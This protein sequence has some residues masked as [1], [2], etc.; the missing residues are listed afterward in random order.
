[1]LRLRYA[2]SHR[3][4]G[5]AEQRPALPS[6]VS[7]LFAATVTQYLA[8]RY[9]GFLSVSTAGS[10]NFTLTAADG[11]LLFLDDQPMLF[12]N[13]NSAPHELPGPLTPARG[14]TVKAPYLAR[15]A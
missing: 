12:I 8:Q 6:R 14:H 4:S 3:G 15:G 1:M 2:F 7:F 5:A 9:S 13:N 11:A 10:Y